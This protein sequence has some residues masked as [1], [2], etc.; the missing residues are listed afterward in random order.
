VIGGGVSEAG[1]LLLGPA[2][3]SYEHYLTGRAYRQLAE[4]RLAEL[5]PDAGLIGAADLARCA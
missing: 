5:G 4:L 1:E 2:R 3:A